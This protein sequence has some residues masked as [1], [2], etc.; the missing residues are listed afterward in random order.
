MGRAI[1]HPVVLAPEERA[2]LESLTKKGKAQAP[3]IRR[4]RILLLL[5]QSEA[6]PKWPDK[7]VSQACGVSARTLA[8]LR[9]RFAEERLGAIRHHS[10]EHYR[11]RKIDGDGEAQLAMI[12][13]SDPPEGYARWSLRLLADKLVSLDINVSYETVRRTL[14]KT[15]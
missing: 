8:R 15:P 2:Q 9:K 4:A 11:P 3:V 14:K 13:C 1:L 5:D 7:S 10:P 6:G 12:A